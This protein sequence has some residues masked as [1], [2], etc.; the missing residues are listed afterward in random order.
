VRELRGL[1]AQAENTVGEY[2]MN[3]VLSMEKPTRHPE[4]W[5]MLNGLYWTP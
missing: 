4:T 1:L 5:L 2:E 3:G